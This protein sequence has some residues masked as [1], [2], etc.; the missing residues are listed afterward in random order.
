MMVIHTLKGNSCH[1][2]CGGPCC[3]YGR[4]HSRYEMDFRKLGWLVRSRGI[5]IS[6]LNG[7]WEVVLLVKVDHCIY[8][9]IDSSYTESAAY[10]CI[11]LLGDAQRIGY[12]YILNTHTF[13]F[14]LSCQEPNYW[15]FPWRCFSSCQ[16]LNCVCHAYFFGTFAVFTRIKYRL[17]INC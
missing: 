6:F 16:C 9:G 15:R 10:R 14:L 2:V 12:L 8:G 17:V 11:Q 7:R 4:S 3:F 1:W 5:V 13:F